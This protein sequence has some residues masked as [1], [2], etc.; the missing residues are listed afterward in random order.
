MY[1]VL[2]TLVGSGRLQPPLSS[3]YHHSGLFYHHSQRIKSAEMLCLMQFDLSVTTTQI[4]LGRTLNVLSFALSTM[5]FFML[6]CNR[7]RSVPWSVLVMVQLEVVV[8]LVD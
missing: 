6:S 7:M 4:I 1:R 8:V 2:P 3:F 5:T